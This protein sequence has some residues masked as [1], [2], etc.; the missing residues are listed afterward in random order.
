M[1][2][3]DYPSWRWGLSL[4]ALKRVDDQVRLSS[5]VAETGMRRND[6]I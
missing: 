6:I 1:E 4:I 5:G 3:L 2:V